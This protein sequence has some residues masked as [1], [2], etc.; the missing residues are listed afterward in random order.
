L[1]FKELRELDGLPQKIETLEREQRALADALSKPDYFKR[2]A[3][4][5]RADQ[6]RGQ[7]L[8]D[9][10]LKALE[11]WELLEQKRA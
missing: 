11:R 2:D 7:I 8:E 3:R 6:E 10:L 9:E 4:L 1:S 5:L